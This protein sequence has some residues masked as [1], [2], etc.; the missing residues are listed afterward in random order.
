MLE[1]YWTENG[2]EINHPAYYTQGEVE[3]ID[4]IKSAVK[5]LNGMEA[6]CVANAMKYLWRWKQKNGRKDIEKAKWY[7]DKLL[8]ETEKWK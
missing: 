4:A 3:C 5:G 2:N 1:F 7:I 6:V 8:E